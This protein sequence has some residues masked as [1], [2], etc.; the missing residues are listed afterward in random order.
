MS[1]LCFDDGGN[2]L[3]SFI[4]APSSLGSIVMSVLSVRSGALSSVCKE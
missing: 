2:I 4:C 3:L 1:Y